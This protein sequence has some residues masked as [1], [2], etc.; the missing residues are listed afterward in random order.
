MDPDRQE[1]GKE[2]DQRRE[3]HLETRMMSPGMS[4]RYW[5]A[6]GMDG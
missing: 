4:G 2:I 1:I 3:P 6:T 5:D